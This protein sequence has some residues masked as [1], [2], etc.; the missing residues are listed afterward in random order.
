MGD[1]LFDHAKF[2][3]AAT[4][5]AFILCCSAVARAEDRLTGM[6]RRVGFDQ[7]LDAKLPLDA[8][9]QDEAGRTVHLGDYFGKRPVILTLNYFNCPMLCTIELNGLVRGLLPLSFDIGDQF[10]MV[11]VSINPR[12]TP[13]LAKAKKASYIKRYGR[14]GAERGWHFLTGDE[15]SIERVTRAVGFRYQYDRE[16]DQYA[17]AAGIVLATP[18]GRVSRYFY[19]IEYPPR[20]LRLAIIEASEQRIGSTV[21]QILLVCFHYDAATGKYNL[22]IMNMIRFF[23]VITVLALGTFMMVMLRRERRLG[24]RGSVEAYPDSSSIRSTDRSGSL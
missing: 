12:E 15:A 2:R 23:G 3:R 14:A 4:V 7:R 1:R 16:S 19:G 22:A 8:A 5:L 24:H 20:D 10:E 18:Q 13:A 11:T 17:H 6:L 21:D 9:F